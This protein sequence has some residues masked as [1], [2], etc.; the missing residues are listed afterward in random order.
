MNLYGT[1]VIAQE[2]PSAI[3]LAGKTHGKRLGYAKILDA[4]RWD[5]A[6]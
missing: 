1:S 3:D 2:I 6:A 5:F 4:N